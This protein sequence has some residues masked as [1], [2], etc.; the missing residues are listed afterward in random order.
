[1]VNLFLKKIL[2]KYFDS[3]FGIFTTGIAQALSLLRTRKSKKILWIGDSHASFISE[4]KL[5]A[6]FGDKSGESLVWIGPRLMYSISQKGFPLPVRIAC[7]LVMKKTNI[8][9]VLG[10]I[11]VR[12]HLAQRSELNFEFIQDYVHEVKKLLQTY[13]L[14]N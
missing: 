2:T 11:D 12:M 8:V 14:K 13:C 5:S 9:F 3:K 10:E 6:M 4:I 1:M 7:R